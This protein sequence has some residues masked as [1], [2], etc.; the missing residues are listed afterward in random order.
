MHKTLLSLAAP[1]HFPHRV[2][3][4]CG[5]DEPYCP[6]PAA[7]LQSM[8]SRE[9]QQLRTSQTLPT[10]LPDNKISYTRLG[11]VRPTEIARVE[12]ASG[13]LC[14]IFS[15]TNQYFSA[16]VFTSMINL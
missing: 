13:P 3:T 5:R 6:S 8:Q 14:T 12:A 16:K 10:F 2:Y 7:C 11:V 1:Q 4:N 15:R 9:G